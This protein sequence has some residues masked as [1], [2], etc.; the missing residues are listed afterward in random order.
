MSWMKSDNI[1][2]AFASD[3]DSF[4]DTNNHGPRCPVC[5]KVMS[6]RAL[7]SKPVREG[8]EPMARFEYKHDCGAEIVI[9]NT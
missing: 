1:Y 8:E 5:R 3:I 4:S 6:V 7:Y 2:S 9:F